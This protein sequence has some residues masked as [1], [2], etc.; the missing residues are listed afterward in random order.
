MRCIFCK[1]KDTAVIETRLSDDGASVRR[2]RECSHCRMRFTTH[3][4]NEE[5]PILVIKRDGRRERF[6]RD[7]L[8]GGVLK[9]VEKTTVSAA[10]VEKIVQLVESQITRRETGEIESQSIGDIV[11]NQLKKFDKIAYIRFASVF[12]RFVDVEELQDEIHKL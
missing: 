4:R 3:E 6:D 2:R 9:A 10:Q 12:R 7:K 8:R 1:K 5:L 11:A